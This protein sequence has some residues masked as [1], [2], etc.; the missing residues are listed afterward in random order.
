MY[1]GAPFRLNKYISR[2]RFE[3][4]FGSIR[5]RFQKDVGHYDGFVHMRKMEESLN[6]NMAEKFNPLWINVLDKIMMEWF[7]KYAPGFMFIGRKPHPFGNESHT[8]CCCLTSIFWRD[9]IVE[10]KYRP[11]PLGQKEYNN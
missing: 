4:I 8:I 3:G 9:H 1:G 5:Y 2:I 6:L 11:G 7:N 10:V